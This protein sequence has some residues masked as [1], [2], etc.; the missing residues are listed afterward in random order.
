MAV[1]LVVA[2]PLKTTP[3]F[4][5][6]FPQAGD[7]AR[8]GS[9]FDSSPLTCRFA[10]VLSRREL[11]EAGV[12]YADYMAM[13]PDDRMVFYRN[14]DNKTDRE[15]ILFLRAQAELMLGRAWRRQKHRIVAAL[16]EYDAHYGITEDDLK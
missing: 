15:K 13:S 14:L 8:W 7:W 10:F 6:W 9:Q 2:S 3:H 12:K 1:P 11:R 4:S 16:R 5:I